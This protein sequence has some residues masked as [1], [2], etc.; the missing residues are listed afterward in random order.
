MGSTATIRIGE[1]QVGLSLTL[2]ALAEIEDALGAPSL[3]ELAVKLANPSAGQL[4]VILKALMRAA[5]DEDAFDRLEGEGVNLRE[6][7]AAIAALFRDGLGGPLPGKS[8]QTRLAGVA[9]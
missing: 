8:T 9:G 5:G 1:R 7:L 6:V 3:S 4:L 2:G